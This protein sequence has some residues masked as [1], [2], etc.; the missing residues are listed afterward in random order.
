VLIDSKQL[1]KDALLKS[2]RQF[3]EAGDPPYVDFFSHSGD[4]LQNIFR[5]IGLPGG[6]VE[7]YKE[8]CKKNIGAVRLFEGVP[9]LLTFLKEN[10]FRC[11]LCTGKDRVRTIE[12][13]RHFSLLDY[14]D[15]VVCS[16]DVQYPKPHAESLLKISHYLA[17]PGHNMIMVGD[18]KN[19]ILCARNASVPSIGVTWGEYPFSLDNDDAPD[20]L[21][22]SMHELRLGILQ[23]A[24]V[25]PMSVV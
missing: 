22:S 25:M 4:S 13:L 14:F 15:I 7:P 9:P 16:D 11:G 19:D 5:K 8:F 2:Y 3:Y 20:L 17:I 10:H 12:I 21:V 23:M 1:Q 18:A 24:F 6:M